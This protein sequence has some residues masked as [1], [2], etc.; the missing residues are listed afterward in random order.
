MFLT[1]LLKQPLTFDMMYARILENYTARNITHSTDI[2]VAFQGNLRVMHAMTG[3][4]MKNEKWVN[5][6]VNAFALLA[7]HKQ[8]EM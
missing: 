3:W 4:R 6:T 8:L 2:L 1:K 5:Q 7:P